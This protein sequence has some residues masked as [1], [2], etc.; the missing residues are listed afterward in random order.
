MPCVVADTSPL[1]YLAKLDR[2]TLL[3]ELYQSVN[4]PEVVWRE[5][6]AATEKHPEILP[7]LT[8]ARSDGWLI[9]SRLHLPHALP[10]LGMLDAGEREAIELANEL[11]ADLLIVDDEAGRNAAAKL[12]FSV[13]GTLGVLIS[14]K[15][16][17]LLATLK[18]EIERLCSETTF[19]ISPGLKSTALRRA[20]ESTIQLP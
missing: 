17:G 18:P 6:L 15:Q 2:L 8:A 4:V 20:G 5:T 13:T 3:R 12:G 16:S 11:H 19:R 10:G 14:A 9:V 1:F 7:T